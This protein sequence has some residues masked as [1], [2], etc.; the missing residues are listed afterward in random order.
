MCEAVCMHARL[1]GGGDQIESLP[2]L[3]QG[4][5]SSLSLE[6]ENFGQTSV[7]T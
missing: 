5:A 1:S 4:K 7:Y 2:L 6:R 3:L